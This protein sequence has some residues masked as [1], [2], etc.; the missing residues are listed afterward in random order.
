[1][2]SGYYFYN[3]GTSFVVPYYTYLGL[4]EA[5]NGK[6]WRVI[7]TP[8]LGS[9]AYPYKN[10]IDFDSACASSSY[11]V[12]D[13]G[14]SAM[15]WNGATWT[16][17]PVAGGA[18]APQTEMTCV[19]GSDCLALGSYLQ[20]DVSPAPFID[21]WNGAQWSW[22]A[23]PVPEDLV[24]SGLNSVACISSKSCEAVGYAFGG[25]KFTTFPIADRWNG[26]KWELQ[27]M[28]N[29]SNSIDTE[30]TGV[31]CSKS[32]CMAVGSWSSGNEPLAELWNGSAWAIEATPLPKGDDAG[33]L[34]GVSC[35]SPTS[36]LAVGS[37]QNSSFDTLELTETWNG[38]AW[39]V[40]PATNPSPDLTESAVGCSSSSACTAVGEAVERYAG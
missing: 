5:W 20:G 38:K 27:S 37:F 35:T 25:K 10:S 29:V 31:S 4:A 17:M 12:V 6:S 39:S 26:S 36:C 18:M 32:M 24:D 8:T 2:A 9:N 28:P 33:N 34:T 23:A 14:A 21:T 16:T 7:S 3:R 11:C 15:S 40:D 1:V 19:T 30:M 13:G 22:Q